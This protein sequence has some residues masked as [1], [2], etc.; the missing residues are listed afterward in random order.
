MTDLSQTYIHIFKFLEHPVPYIFYITSTS[1]TFDIWWVGKYNFRLFSQSQRVLGIT[2]HD[3]TF[4]LLFAEL[5]ISSTDPPKMRRWARGWCDGLKDKPPRKR[6][7]CPNGF[8]GGGNTKTRQRKSWWMCVLS[9]LVG[10]A[11][12][13]CRKLLG[14]SD[15]LC[16]WSC[17]FSIQLII[18]AMGKKH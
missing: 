3:Q 17:T 13:Y 9:G 6:F 7:E 5:S 14:G 1:S 2:F 4:K 12:L 10:G 18:I 15:D 16:T 8:V 11:R